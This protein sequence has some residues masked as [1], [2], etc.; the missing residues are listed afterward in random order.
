MRRP[1]KADGRLLRDA[2]GKLLADC[3]YRETAAELARLANASQEVQPATL[4]S[5]GEQWQTE[6]S[7]EEKK[8]GM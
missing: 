1:L 8:E 7:W 3:F 6:R 2:E 4:P 5:S